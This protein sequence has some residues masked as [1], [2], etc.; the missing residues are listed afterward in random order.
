MLRAW[1][2]RLRR[3]TSGSQEGTDQQREVWQTQYWIRS[4]HIQFRNHFGSVPDADY[5]QLHQLHTI[6]RH[7]FC[8]QK[9]CTDPTWSG[10]VI[11]D[12][13]FKISLQNLQ[14]F[15][16]NTTL[17]NIASCKL[18]L[19]QNEFTFC[20]QEISMNLFCLLVAGSSDCAY[21][22]K[23]FNP[24]GVFPSRE[25]QGPRWLYWNDDAIHLG[26]DW[27][28]KRNHLLFTPLHHQTQDLQWWWFERHKR[29]DS[30]LRGYLICY[31]LCLK[32]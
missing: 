21:F 30:K 29:S 5:C 26:S 13:P 1:L 15:H 4:I 20:F 31:S 23:P 22:W 10:I 17:I 11:A 25:L 8:R 12:W 32:F 7:I 16:T 18:C 9:T 27:F 14:K 19:L 6:Y 3:R 2:L 28:S 24:W